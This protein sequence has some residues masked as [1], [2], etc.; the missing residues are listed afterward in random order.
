MLRYHIPGYQANGLSHNA[1]IEAYLGCNGCDSKPN[2][3][4]GNMRHS[5][6]IRRVKVVLSA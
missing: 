3:L 5:S 2:E 6:C 4:I 1:L